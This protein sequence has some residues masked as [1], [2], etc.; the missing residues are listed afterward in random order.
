MNMKELTTWV[1][2]HPTES[3]V[4]GGGGVI[5][6]LWLL[7]AFSSSA[8]AAPSQD[9]LAAAYYAAEAQQAVVGGQIQ[10]NNADAAAATAQAGINA[11]A[12]TTIAATNA[13]AATTINGQ[14][15]GAAQTINAQEGNVYQ[16]LAFDQLQATNINAG[17]LA[18]MNVTN[19]NAAIAMNQ[20]DVFGAQAMTIIPAEIA[21]AGGKGFAINLPGGQSFSIGGGPTPSPAS[22]IGLG[23]TPEQASSLAAEQLKAYGLG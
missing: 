22:F 23:Y 19:T 1:E 7:G 14:N 2:A 8:Q 3:I 20:Q 13:T 4:I 6:L 5:L 21:A 10:M 16:A 11:N 18:S 17:T 9:P 15:V 12:A